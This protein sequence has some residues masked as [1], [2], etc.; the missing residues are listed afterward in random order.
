MTAEVRFASA[1]G[2][3]GGPMRHR[4]GGVTPRVSAL[5][6]VGLASPSSVGAATTSQN[7]LVSG[8]TTIGS[9]A[10]QDFPPGSIA[11]LMIDDD[12]GDITG[13]T[14]SI[15]TYD[16]HVMVGST[17]ITIHVTI[18]DASPPTGT[19]DPD[20]GERH[21][22]LHTTTTLAIDPSTSCVIGP[23]EI[24][25]STTNAGGTDFDGD[26]LT[27]TLTAQ[28][29]HIPAIV[30]TGGA[31]ACPNS[32]AGLINGAPPGLS[33]PTD[34]SAEV[35][36]LTATDQALPPPTTAAPPTTATPTTEPP[37]APPAS[38]VNVEPAL[39]G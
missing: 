13:G 24:Q 28:N 30:G 21:L 16:V 35:L 19:L 9:N 26:P 7:F 37:A 38:P 31:G 6:L 12:T 33:L 29:F 22:D 18:A 10:A 2:E 23:F 17:A 1:A 4:I 36:G 15:P 27:G 5:L 39:T 8:S 14:F 20:T 3:S 34:T 25:L 11:Q 32:I